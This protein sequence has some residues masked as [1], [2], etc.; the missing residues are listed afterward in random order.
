EH[1][2]R[3]A[4]ACEWQNGGPDVARFRGDAEAGSAW[5]T[6]FANPLAR[7]YRPEV[8][9]P[10]GDCPEH[11]EADERH[12]AKYANDVDDRRRAGGGR[13]R[14]SDGDRAIRVVAPSCA[15]DGEDGRDQKN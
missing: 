8:E 2:R 3:G 13:G 4:E 7:R 6:D 9:V 12:Q 1:R 14:L 15:G 11:K 10:T 5:R